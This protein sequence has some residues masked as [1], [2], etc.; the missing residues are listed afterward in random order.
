MKLKRT[1]IRE[2][3]VRFILS[4]LDVV[5]DSIETIQFLMKHMVNVEEMYES[6]EAEQE[7]EEDKA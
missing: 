6:F 1:E 3:Y 5:K 7:A 4:Q 2:E